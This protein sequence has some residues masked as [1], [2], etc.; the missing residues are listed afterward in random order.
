MRLIETV[1]LH[2]T[3]RDY[4]GLHETDRDCATARD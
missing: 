2:E 1:G 3:D 4:A